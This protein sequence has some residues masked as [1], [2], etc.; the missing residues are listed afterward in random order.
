MIRCVQCG[1]SRLDPQGY[2]CAFCG[3]AP[4]I[5]T[6]PCQI[7]EDTKAKL[8]AHA[9]ELRAFGVTLGERETLGKSVDALGVIALVLTV[10]DSLDS[11]LLHKLVLFLRSLDIPQEEIL[12]LRLDEPER[13]LD[14]YRKGA[15]T[16]P[17]GNDRTLTEEPSMPG[18]ELVY[19]YSHKDQGLR[20]EL[21]AHLSPLER[22]GLIS[23]WYDRRIVP[24]KEFDRE[25]DARFDRAQIILLLV[26]ANFIASD[27]CYSQEMKKA[28]E[29]HEAGD[30]RVIPVIV[31]PVDWSGTPFRKL[32]GLP[33]DGRAVTSGLTTTRLI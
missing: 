24:G 29:R 11:G 2:K 14:H 4:G 18:I 32:L 21:A 13:V 22:E 30:A 20:D 7:T 8:L 27:Y 5:R 15:R 10:A 3:G 28:M 25:I 16:R 19:S 9:K 17:G 12:R 31:R 6:E 33:D 26:S 1:C 23:S